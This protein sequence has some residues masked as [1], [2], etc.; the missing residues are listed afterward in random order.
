METDDLIQKTIRTE[1]ADSTV[2]TIAHRLNT[3]LDYDRLEKEGMR[4]RN[5]NES[6]TLR[7][8]VLD[9]GRIVEFDSPNKLIEEKG[10]FFS[11]ARDAGLV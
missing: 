1:F 9:A 3:I 8:M 11:M 2:L 10:V 4:E 7:V 6:T 5:Y